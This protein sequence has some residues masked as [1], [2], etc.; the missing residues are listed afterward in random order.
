MLGDLYFIMFF[1]PGLFVA[2][3]L[4]LAFHHCYKHMDGTNPENFRA[5]S[6]SCFG[7]CFLQPSDVANHETWIVALCSAAISWLICVASTTNV[8][9]C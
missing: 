6:E 1:P 9:R 8:C 4:A 2:I 3:A 5:H 7:I